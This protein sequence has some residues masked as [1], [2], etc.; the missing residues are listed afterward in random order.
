M[1][2]SEERVS[3]F[4]GYLD[5]AS[6]QQAKP[7]VQRGKKK[8]RKGWLHCMYR[9]PTA[10]SVTCDS[11]ASC[12]ADLASLCSMQLE[13]V[14]AANSRFN[15]TLEAEPAGRPGMTFFT[16]PKF[17][18]WRFFEFRLLKAERWIMEQS[19]GNHHQFESLTMH[20]CRA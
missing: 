4:F 1:F 18:I 10:A 20:F 8:E 16:H 5:V 17:T 9:L 6:T 14:H 13:A 7:I 15:C 12:R 2:E 19:L 3:G 11:K